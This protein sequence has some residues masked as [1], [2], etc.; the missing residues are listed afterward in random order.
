LTINGQG[1][2]RGIVVTQ[3]GRVDVQRCV[4]SNMGGIGI[5]VDEGTPALKLSI[6]DTR[7]SNNVGDGV[8]IDSG[9]LLMANSNVENNGGSGVLLSN[10]T[11]PNTIQAVIRSSVLAGNASHGVVAI[12]LVTAS[13]IQVTVEE[14][15][16]VSRSTLARNYTFDVRQLAGAVL[17]SHGNNALSGDGPGNVSGTITQVG[18]D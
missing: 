17:R 3:A 14:S 1:G 10:D 15:S 6:D 9:D 7:V 8:R 18:L 2:D 16:A 5:R 11:P 12:G 13:A 4:V